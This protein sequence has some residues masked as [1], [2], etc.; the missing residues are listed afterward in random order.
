MSTQACLAADGVV[1]E[2]AKKLEEARKDRS[3]KEAA[4]NKGKADLASE[5]RQEFDSVAPSHSSL[6]DRNP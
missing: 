5:R 4:M 2:A 3:I 1:D 6:Q